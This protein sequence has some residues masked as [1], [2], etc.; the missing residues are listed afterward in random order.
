MAD[1]NRTI[2]IIFDGVDRVSDDIGNIGNNLQ[3]FT[4]DVESAT[5]PMA[6]F[7]KSLL[8]AEGALVAIGATMAGI[9]INQAGQ[10]RTEV[11]EIGTLFNGTTDQTKALGAEI[12]NFSADSAKSISEINQS[13]YTAI[14]TGTDYADA[15]K[16]V[17]SA[18]ALAVGGRANLSEV[19]TLLASS[20]N[21]Y[22]ASVQE[23]Q[24]YS[25]TLFTTVQ[26]GATS[27]PELASSLAGVTSIASAAG[28]P[29]EDLNAALA[30]ITVG[31]VST[32]ETVTQLKALFNELL[33]PSDELSSA[34]GT[35]SL[36]ADGLDG[37]M[38]RLAEVTG[39]SAEQM[40]KLFSSSEAVQAALSLA[41]DSA[42]AYAGSLTAMDERQ[43]AALKSAE[44][45]RSEFEATN[46]TFRNIINATFIGA[47]TPLLDEY[48]DVVQAIGEVF[49]A[50]EFDVPDSAF[51][52]LYDGVEAAS[53]DVTALLQGIAEALPEA[54]DNIDF[55]GLLD[56]FGL[57]S[58]EIGSIFGG[59]DL[60][61]ADDLQ[62]AIQALIDGVTALTNFSAG[63]VDALQPFI[64]S[65]G[66]LINEINSGDQSLIKFVGQIGGLATALNALAP[67]VN[68]AASVMILFGGAGGIGGA[69][70][71]VARFLPLLANPVTGLIAVFGGLLYLANDTQPLRNFVDGI[72]GL[73]TSSERAARQQRQLTA[74]IE[75]F[76]EAMN[77]SAEAL[78]DA[79]QATRDLYAAKQFAEGIDDRIAEGVRFSSKSYEE[80]VSILADAGRAQE[81]INAINEAGTKRQKERTDAITKAAQAWGEFT[82][83]QKAL[84]SEE[85]KRTYELA[86]Q[87]ANQ[88]G[89]L[90]AVDET[91]GA[92]KDQA[93]ALKEEAKLRKE[94]TDV[95]LRQTQQS[96]DFRV[97]LEKIASSEKLKSLEF[98]FELD[99][100]SLRQNGQ[101][102]RSI[103]DGISNTAT[104][105]GETLSSLG[106]L[107]TGFTTTTSSGYR[108]IFELVQAEENRRDQALELQ[109]QITEAQVDQMEAQTKMLEARA[110]ALASGY[111]AIQID[112]T[113]L[114]PHLE[115]FMWEVVQAVQVRVNAEGMDMLLGFEGGV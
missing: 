36:K 5:E 90:K 12:L 45:L 4:G 59:L 75:L 35:V 10:F 24:D 43:G 65:V 88:R 107:L 83:A 9:A 44:A 60:T 2:Q 114:Q 1:I 86:A 106:G 40:V 81:T 42:G 93:D 39:G 15:V 105:T 46:Q 68:A 94:A 91:K 101:T 50:L 95:L 56:A 17:A 110:D 77:G 70:T 41:N 82:D 113:G 92:S 100:E 13:V 108:E 99:I 112:G 30:A 87:E 26:K 64:T 76:N 34:L 14:S 25:D 102:A 19:T 32:S 57:L 84:L 52:P 98:K 89:L 79:D 103:I 109:K 18:E 78:R 23:A 73:E 51:A 21:A 53:A 54:L 69:A 74:D 29:F 97:E 31:G 55:T 47:G 85:E 104:S 71:S 38:A 61:N 62:V 28:V 111:A 58:D 48:R 6:N 16:T 96:L 11:A 27:I 20:M 67:L 49:K 115:A 80:Q 37:V 33:K 63:A 8:T 72:L 7:T 66:E 22:G 3:R